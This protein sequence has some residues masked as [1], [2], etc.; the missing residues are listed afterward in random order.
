VQELEAK[1]RTHEQ[2]GIGA[3][4]EIQSAARKVLEENKRLRAMLRTRGVPEREIAAALEQASAAPTLMSML[5]RRRTNGGASPVDSNVD[6]ESESSS[7]IPQTP[8]IDLAPG[9]LAISPQA[10][11]PHN[12][13][14]IYNPNPVVLN[15]E[16]S[17]G[18]ANA[19][20]Q[21]IAMAPMSVVKHEP[22]PH[23]S[24]PA[25][26]NPADAWVYQAQSNYATDSLPQS[27]STS[28]VNAANIIRAQTDVGPE[29]EA[30]LG[31][32]SP[33]QD[34]RVANPIVFNVIEKYSNQPMRM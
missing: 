4:T 10:A 25:V 15:P 29:L 6:G 19:H 21:P 16:T 26:Q 33:Y 3:S 18:L 24:Y 7:V 1:L 17:S 20:F 9:P 28:C 34:C 27:Y 5:E 8:G 22:G 11:V 2:M 32:R 23:Y 13:A 30:D 14:E 12:G 31:C